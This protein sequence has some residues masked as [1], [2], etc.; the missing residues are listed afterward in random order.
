M[1]QHTEATDVYKNELLKVNNKNDK[2]DQYWFLTSEQPGNPTT[3][4]R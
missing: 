3:Y 1:L 4:T 2:T